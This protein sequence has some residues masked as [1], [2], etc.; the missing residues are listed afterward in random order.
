M[1]DNPMELA[2]T[3]F[4]AA[5]VLTALASV[6]TMLFAR[7]TQVAAGRAANGNCLLEAVS[8]PTSLSAHKPNL[9]IVA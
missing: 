9:K 1:I 3:V 6:F 7:E 2:L 8:S 4:A 5:L